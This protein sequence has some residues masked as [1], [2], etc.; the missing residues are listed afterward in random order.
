[1]KKSNTAWQR[2]VAAARQT[3]ANPGDD[4]LAMAAVERPSLAS[5]LNHFSWRALG[6]SLTLMIVSIAANYSTV[7]SVVEVEHESDVDPVEEM[8][9]TLS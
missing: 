2:L 5:A 4:A 6:F 7:T 9:L 3:P 1:M 8:L